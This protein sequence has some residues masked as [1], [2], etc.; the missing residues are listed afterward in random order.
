MKN[1]AN[2]TPVTTTVTV[3]NGVGTFGNLV[4][5]TAGN[6]TLK[7]SGTGGMTSPNS[8]SRGS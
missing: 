4:L 3:S 5:D 7:A 1:C 2:Q 8:A 6:Y